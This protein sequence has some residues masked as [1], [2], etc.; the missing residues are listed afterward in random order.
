[1]RKILKRLGMLMLISVSCMSQSV[2]IPLHAQTMLAAPATR[3]EVKISPTDVIRKGFKVRVETPKGL[4]DDYENKWVIKMSE[5]SSSGYDSCVYS[6][7][8]IDDQR[9]YCVD[10]LTSVMNGAQDYEQIS[11]GAYVNDA[12]VREK[13]S[14]ITALGYGFQGDTSH[15]MDF[16]TQIC[17]WQTLHEWKP[18]QYPAISYI[19]KDIQSKIAL[20]K[21]RLALMEEEV[22]FAGEQLQLQRPWRRT[23]CDLAR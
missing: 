18:R 10:P 1:M 19:H 22:S 14:Y 9:V 13:L 3:E 15:E 16:A 5:K 6:K 4:H 21:A 17:I 20:I 8:W 23:C 12:A 7:I 2:Q 11:F